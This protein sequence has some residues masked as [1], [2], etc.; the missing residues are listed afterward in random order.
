MDILRCVGDAHTRRLM[1]SSEGE[2]GLLWGLGVQL[3][4]LSTARRTHTAAVLA[5]QFDVRAAGVPQW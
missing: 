1:K 3:G 4:L 2:G 5:G